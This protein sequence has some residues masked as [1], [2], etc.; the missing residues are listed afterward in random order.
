MEGKNK[1][2]KKGEISTSGF[3]AE[4]QQYFLFFFFFFLLSFAFSPFLFSLSHSFFSLSSRL[5]KR[6]AEGRAEE[7]EEEEK[8]AIFRRWKGIGRKK[9]RA[10][11][12]LEGMQ[13][14]AGASTVKRRWIDLGGD[15][16]LIWV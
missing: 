7:E 16:L 12:A 8:V 11:P 13:G 10:S 14:V 2:T 9:S 15:S 5:R 3:C 6:D 4:P 1:K